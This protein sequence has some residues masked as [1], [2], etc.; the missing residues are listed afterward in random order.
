M[1]RAGNQPRSQ[2][3]FRITIGIPKESPPLS[4]SKKSGDTDHPNG[5]LAK[6]SD[7]TV[8]Y[9]GGEA[10][11]RGGGWIFQIR[12][13]EL[14]PSQRWKKI[15]DELNLLRYKDKLLA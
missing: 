5:R 1:K 3:G 13:K 15:Q 14:T 11:A 10:R 4:R 2:I 8:L 12:E 6:F 7:C 9:I